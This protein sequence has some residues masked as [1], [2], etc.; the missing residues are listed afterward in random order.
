MNGGLSIERGL[1][2][3]V[4]AY[5][6]G[7]SIDLALAKRSITDLTE[8][9]QIKHKGH[10]PAYFQFEDA[11]LRVTQASDPGPK[12]SVLLEMRAGGLFAIHA[13]LLA[14]DGSI[15]KDGCS[16]VARSLAAKWGDAP[17]RIWL[18]RDAHVR[19]ALVDTCKLVFER[20]VEPAAWF[21]TE[22]TAIVPVAAS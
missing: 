11:P 5:D 1:V 13:D 14:D 22:P 19:V 8:I 20:Y 21:G 18:D 15:P 17:E 10:A 7:L 16:D 9:A 12:V 2:H 4:Q 6:I 3:V